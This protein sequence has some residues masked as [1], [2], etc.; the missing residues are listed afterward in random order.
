MR[1]DHLDGPGGIGLELRILGIG[2]DLLQQVV[3]ALAV[4]DADALDVLTE[5]AAKMAQANLLFP[6]IGKSPSSMSECRG[7]RQKWQSSKTCRETVSCMSEFR[8]P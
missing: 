5:A 7:M 3:G 2:A 6:Y 8:E 4:A 1:V